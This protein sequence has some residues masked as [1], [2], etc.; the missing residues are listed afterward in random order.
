MSQPTTSLLRHHTNT[1][2]EKKQNGGN[3]I[4]LIL[5][6]LQEKLKTFRQ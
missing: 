6:I 4:K 2:K 3:G 1:T 5:T